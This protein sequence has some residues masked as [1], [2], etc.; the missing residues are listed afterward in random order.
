[1]NVKAGEL[2]QRIT[3]ERP[4]GRR[5]ELGAKRRGEWIPVC[6]LWADVRMESASEVDQ[7]AQPVHR[8]TYKVR[9]RYTSELTPERRIIFNDTPLD[10]TGITHDPKRREMIAVCVNNRDG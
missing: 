9:C 4:S 2:R 10:I 8:I 3:I 5:D 1:M 6:Q 7:S